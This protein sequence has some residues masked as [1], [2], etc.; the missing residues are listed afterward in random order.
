V[1][2][3]PAPLKAL[4][5]GTPIWKEVLVALLTAA[6]AVLSL[7]SHRLGFRE[8][9][10]SRVNAVALRMLTPLALLLTTL[11]LEP[12]FAHEIDTAGKFAAVVEFAAIVSLTVAALWLF[13]L[14]VKLISER[15]IESPR[16]EEESL[17]SNF[18]RLAGRIVGGLGAVFIASWGLHKLGVPALGVLT[19]LGVGSAGVALAVQPALTSVLAG[20]TIYHE[21]AIRVGDFIRFGDY[22]GHVEDIGVRSTRIR[23]ADQTLVSVPNSMTPWTIPPRDRPMPARIELEG[24][25]SLA[26]APEA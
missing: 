16:V 19:G 14:T 1:D 11:I 8:S 10:K 3:V 4:W 18:V 13:W 21:K 7:L 20:L 9:T 25:S 2:R 6:A 23:A 22:S 12:F 15:I 17:D 5:L 26:V 24:H